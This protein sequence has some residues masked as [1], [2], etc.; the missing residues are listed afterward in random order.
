MP[1]KR[2]RLFFGLMGLTTC[3]LS[4]QQLPSKQATEPPSRQDL[5]EE[6]SKLT[7]DLRA[8]QEGLAQDKRIAGT[9]PSGWSDQLAK[10]QLE[11]TNRLKYAVLKARRDELRAQ[12]E[13]ILRE[14]QLYADYQIRDTKELI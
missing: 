9:L 1:I 3:L 5:K 11:N 14:R 7:F 6:V 4:C 2:L 8:A 13:A 10:L 12:L